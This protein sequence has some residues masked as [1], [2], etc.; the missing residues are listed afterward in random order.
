MQSIKHIELLLYIYRNS[1]GLYSSSSSFIADANFSAKLSYAQHKTLKHRLLSNLGQEMADSLLLRS[2]NSKSV[3][4]SCKHLE[5]VPKLI[6]KLTRVIHIDLKS[7]LLKELPNEFGY[8]IQVG[9]TFGRTLRTYMYNTVDGHRFSNAWCFCGGIF[10]Q[11][12]KK[13]YFGAENI[14]C[15]VSNE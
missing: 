12:R 11:Q 10:R 9:F 15:D 7:N 14:F 5:K 13:N 6:G 1:G 3:N 2:L 4:L 8:L